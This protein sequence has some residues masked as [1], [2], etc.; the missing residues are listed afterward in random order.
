[1]GVGGGGGWEGGGGR[2]DALFMKEVRLSVY[3]F[4]VCVV[5]PSD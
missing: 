3:I 2:T 1:M 5:S 4:F